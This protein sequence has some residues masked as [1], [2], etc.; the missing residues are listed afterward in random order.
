MSQENLELVHRLCDAFNRRDLD[1]FLALNASDVEF[2]PY[3][4]A[5][6]GS[7]QGH[8]G[9]GRWW[10]E[11]FDV[12][13][14]WGV[15]VREVRDLGDD[16]TLTTLH[17]R[18]HGGESGTPVAQMLWQVAEWNAEGQIVRVVHHGSKAEALEAVGLSE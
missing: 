13:P 18:G 3:T 15:E 9:I 1:A 14:D 2:T 6:Q 5:V 8:D 4:V 12:F 16:V 11:L 10:R 7:Y 17:A